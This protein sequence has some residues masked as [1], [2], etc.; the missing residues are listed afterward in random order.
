MA[1]PSQLSPISTASAVVFW[2]LWAAAASSACGGE[3][4]ASW[5][6]PYF[7]QL[8]ASLHAAQLAVR[9]AHAHAQRPVGGR[10]GGELG[11]VAEGIVGLDGEG[12]EPG[13]RNVERQQVR[14]EEGRG[15][16]ALREHRARRQ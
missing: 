1:L 11:H 8:S 16:L 5:L 9:Q 7:H 14:D 4:A 2:A 12:A 6:R 13:G 3:A 10:E 15:R